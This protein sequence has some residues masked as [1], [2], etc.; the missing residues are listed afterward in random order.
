MVPFLCEVGF[1]CS[2]F[3]IIDTDG[4]LSLKDVYLVDGGENKNIN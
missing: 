4:N 3:K 1:V 2:S